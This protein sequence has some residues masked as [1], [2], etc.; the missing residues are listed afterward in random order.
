MQINL[1]FIYLG[2]KIKLNIACNMYVMSSMRYFLGKWLLLSFKLF[3]AVKLA[4]KSFIAEWL[5]NWQVGV[6]VLMTNNHLLWRK[7]RQLN[8]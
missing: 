7:E 3:R 1:S 2:S 6:H 4:T 5:C 8:T